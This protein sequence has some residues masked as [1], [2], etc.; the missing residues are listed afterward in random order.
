[1]EVPPDEEEGIPGTTLI[2]M[3]FVTGKGT[4]EVIIHDDDAE[5][6]AEALVKHAHGLC[7]E[8]AQRAKDIRESAGEGVIGR[9]TSNLS[10]A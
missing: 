3:S 10:E 8:C 4:T 7:E 2:T 1:M 5:Q 9:H 6:L